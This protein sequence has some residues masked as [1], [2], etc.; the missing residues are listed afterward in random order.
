MVSVLR[1]NTLLFQNTEEVTGRKED[2]IQKS[3]LGFDFLIKDDISEE[4]LCRHI[5]LQQVYHQHNH[6]LD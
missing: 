6:D 2:H 3:R 1:S 5:R 4:F